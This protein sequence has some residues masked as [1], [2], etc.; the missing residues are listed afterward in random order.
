MLLQEAMAMVGYDI[1]HL[2]WVSLKKEKIYL[3][4]SDSLRVP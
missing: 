1:L 3:S 4:F 2:V